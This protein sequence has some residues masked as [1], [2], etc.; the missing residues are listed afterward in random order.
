[1]GNNLE[2]MMKVMRFANRRG[3]SSFDLYS[4]V[5]NQTTKILKYSLEEKFSKELESKKLDLTSII[6][7]CFFQEMDEDTHTKKNY[8]KNSC[9]HFQPVITDKGM[10]QAFN[11]LPVLDIVKPSYFSKSFYNAY[12]HDL[13]LN[14]VLHN[15]TESGDSFNFYLMGNHRAR[16][17]Q[18]GKGASN[19]EMGPSKFMFGISNANEY[20]DLQK[21]RKIILMKFINRAPGVRK[22]VINLIIVKNS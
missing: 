1:M 8:S 4:L 15:G 19:Q 3:K 22:T 5:P 14:G 13:I 10:C 20:F 7:V 21:S 2:A 9:L 17:T 11:P 18:H 6:P 12:K 16:V